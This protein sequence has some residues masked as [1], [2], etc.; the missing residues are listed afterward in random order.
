MLKKT[1]FVDGKKMSHIQ[2]CLV[3]DSGMLTF[4]SH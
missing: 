4:D 2:E 1:Q 3:F